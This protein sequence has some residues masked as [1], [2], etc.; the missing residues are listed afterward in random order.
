MDD[1]IN[2]FMSGFTERLF[3]DLGP[4][5]SIVLAVIIAVPT[6]FSLFAFTR[7]IPAIKSR[8][9]FAQNKGPDWERDVT[10]QDVPTPEH[11]E[12][13]DQHLR[14]LGMQPLGIWHIKVAYT[15]PGYGWVY[16]SE[17]GK[18]YAE[19][20]YDVPYAPWPAMLQFMS[21]FPDNAMLITSYPAGECIVTPDFMSRFASGS[22]DAALDFH[23][24][25]LK[26]WEDLHGEATRIRTM[27]DTQRC[28][29]IFRNLY[30]KHNDRRLIR[31]FDKV[32][33]WN[34]ASIVVLVLTFLYIIKGSL[35]ILVLLAGVVGYWLLFKM[36][37][38]AQKAQENILNPPG[39]VDAEETSPKKKHS[40]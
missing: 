36:G 33:F 38:V 30:R 25:T 8:I 3:G 6:F 26:E 13:L 37:R 28:A 15:D 20:V 9:A 27:A 29:D 1:F 18:I 34:I 24:A 14:S 40:D 32:L 19:I 11:H 10:G 35:S 23:I 17:S 4:V 12:E 39:A 7:L 22:I 2:E 31:L 16:L 5:T 21:C